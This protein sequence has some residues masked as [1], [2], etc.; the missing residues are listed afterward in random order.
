MRSTA[1]NAAVDGELI[2]FQ[3]DAEFFSA[4]IG[5]AAYWRLVYGYLRLHWRL[6]HDE[7]ADLAQE[8]FAQ[9][10]DKNLLARF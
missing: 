9:L 8:F 6:A 7:A 1:G 5:S 10:V 3:R 2:L 4:H